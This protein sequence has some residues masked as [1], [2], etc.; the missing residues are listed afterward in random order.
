M[1]V[2]NL[3]LSPGIGG[4]PVIYFRHLQTGRIFWESKRESSLPSRDVPSVVFALPLS[5]CSAGGHAAFSANGKVVGYVL[6]RT[7]DEDRGPVWK[8][9][10]R[11]SDREGQFFERVH[12]FATNALLSAGCTVCHTPSAARYGSQPIPRSAGFPAVASYPWC[13]LE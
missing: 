13:C 7:D 4:F 12:S 8:G 6:R 11:P 9:P 10:V 2:P 3:C 5:T 1:G